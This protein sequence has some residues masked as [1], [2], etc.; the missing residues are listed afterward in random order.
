MGVMAA[1]HACESGRALAG[2]FQLG[3]EDFVA[4]WQP[5]GQSGATVVRNIRSF[6]AARESVEAVLDS[7]LV[8]P[9]AMA[10]GS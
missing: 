6:Q 9:R 2:V 8:V 4:C 5:V 10:R 3:E 1:W 7:T